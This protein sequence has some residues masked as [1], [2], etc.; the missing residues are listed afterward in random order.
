MQWKKTGKSEGYTF[1]FVVSCERESK[2]IL[3]ASDLLPNI[4]IHV[5]I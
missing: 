5:Y 4:Y 2:L 3:A 1:V